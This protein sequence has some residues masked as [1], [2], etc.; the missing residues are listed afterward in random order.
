MSKT[1]K[2]YTSLVGL[3]KVNKVFIKELFKTGK[4]FII[5]QIV[6]YIL[7]IPI[8][9]WVTYAPKNFIDSITQDNNLYIALSWILLMIILKY[10]ERMMIF[11]QDL[12]KNARFLTQN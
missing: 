6:I 4:Y 5:F 10:A 9:Y 8:N 2:Q 11:A 1:K 3:F 12:L 7:I